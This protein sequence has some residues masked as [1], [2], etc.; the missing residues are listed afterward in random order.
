MERTIAWGDLPAPDQRRV[1][2]LYGSLEEY[3]AGLEHIGALELDSGQPLARFLGN[4]DDVFLASFY[5][6]GTGVIPVIERLGMDELIR[7]MQV[8]LAHPVGTTNYG[9]RL[10][11]WRSTVVAHPTFDITVVHRRVLA[12]A[13]LD[14]PPVLASVQSARDLLVGCTLTVHSFIRDWYPEAVS[15]YKY[16]VDSTGVDNGA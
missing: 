3:A 10:Q 5:A 16:L 7:P 12:L 15:A 8:A 2:M 6:P 14:S 4:A 1:I 11:E 9:H 13:D